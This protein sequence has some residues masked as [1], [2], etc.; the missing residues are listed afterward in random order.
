[1]EQSTPG[2]GLGEEGA[3]VWNKANLTIS[4]WSVLNTEEEHWDP[5]F[6]E[7]MC[8]QDIGCQEQSELGPLVSTSDAISGGGES[9]L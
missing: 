6:P 8:K 2:M 1:M 9:Y 7:D 4:Q 3:G 5:V